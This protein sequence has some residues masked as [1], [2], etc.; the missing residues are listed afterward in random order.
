MTPTPIRIAAA[1]VI[2]S[3]RKILL[4][5][6]RGSAFFMQPGGKVEGGETPRQ[7]LV[8]ELH[9][10]LGLDVDSADLAFLGRFAAPAANE[11]GATV[12]AELFRLDGVAGAVAAEAEIAEI[13]WVDPTDTGDRVLAPLTRDHVLPLCRP[14][15]TS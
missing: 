10:E 14:L 3:D 7:A 11:P 2:R 8:R 1:I 6:K 12:K 15:E 5:R 9:E 13:A 4:V